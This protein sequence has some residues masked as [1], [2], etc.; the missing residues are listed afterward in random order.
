MGFSISWL[1]II[2]IT[3]IVVVVTSLFIGE[4]LLRKDNYYPDGF[5]DNIERYEDSLIDKERES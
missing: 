5:E 3:T 1:I 4:I 2:I